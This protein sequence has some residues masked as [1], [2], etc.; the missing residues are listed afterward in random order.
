MTGLLSG[1]QSRR[2][3]QVPTPGICSRAEG[4]CW[5]ECW[6]FHRMERRLQRF[7]TTAAAERSGFVREPLLLSSGRGASSPRRVPV[8]RTGDTPRFRGDRS[9]RE[10]LRLPAGMTR[11]RRVRIRDTVKRLTGFPD[12]PGDAEFRGP[13]TWIP[14]HFGRAGGQGFASDVVP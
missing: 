2:F 12:A 14:A 3:W 8:R 7:A 5:L 1:G 10:W 13:R 4:P 6:N 9:A 11:I